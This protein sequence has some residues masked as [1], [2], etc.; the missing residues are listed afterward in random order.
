[1]LCSVGRGYSF[2]PNKHVKSITI[3][4]FYVTLQSSLPQ[5]L[6]N[7]LLTSL[8]PLPGSFVSYMFSLLHKFN[9]CHS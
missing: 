8:P 9:I 3:T 1:M 6:I 4:K 5:V 2:S 7:D